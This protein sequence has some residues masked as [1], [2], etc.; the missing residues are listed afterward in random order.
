MNGRPRL[1]SGWLITIY[2]AALAVSCWLIYLTHL[3]D[4][5]LLLFM[6]G[7]V[8]A[9]FYYP[10]SVYLFLIAVTLPVAVFLV[11]QIVPGGYPYALLRVGF[12]GV[13]VLVI[14]EM[15]RWINNQREA[16]EAELRKSREQYRSLLED[17]NDVAFIVD[18][19]GRFVYISPAIERISSYTVEELIGRPFAEFIH[20]DDLPEL[21][22]KIQAVYQGDS[23][24]KW[25]RVCDRDGTVR[26]VRTSS[27]PLYENGRLVG[28]SGIMVDISD[29]VQTQERLEMRRHQLQLLNEITRAALAE[30]RYLPMLHTLEGRLAELFNADG[31]EITLWNES[32]DGLVAAEARKGGQDHPSQAPAVPAERANT[33]RVLKSGRPQAVDDVLDLP[34]GQSDRSAQNGSRSLL[35]LPLI[36]ENRWLG[37]ASIT[38]AERRQFSEEDLEWAELVTAQLSLAAYKGWALEAERTQQETARA[39][40][41]AG[42]S[43][44]ETLDSDEILDRLLPQVRNVVS[45]DCGVMMLVEGGQVRVVRQLGYREVYS[46]AVEAAISQLAFNIDEMANL[47]AVV[48]KREPLI[49]PDVYAA[50]DW[51]PVEGITRLRCWVGVPILIKGE[52]V[53]LY[54]LESERPGHFSPAHVQLLQA[55]AAQASL[56]LENARLYEQARR[57]MTESETL[58]QV[59]SA[60]VSELDLEKVLDQILEQLEKVVPYDSASVF[61]VEGQYLQILAARGFE[62]PEQVMGMTVP[63]TSTLFAHI[64]ETR[65]PLILQDAQQDARFQGWAGTAGYVRGW[66]GVP[67]MVQGE[68]IGEITVDSRLAEA[69]DIED[70]RLVMDFATEASIAIQHARLYRR[71]METAKRLSIL[72][73]A[74]QQV[75]ASLDPLQL[76]QAVHN[77][78]SQVMSTESFVIA[79]QDDYD[80]TIDVPYLVDRGGMSEPITIPAGSGLSGY[81][82]RSGKS[83]LVVDSTDELEFE[84]VQYGDPGPIRSFLAVPLRRQDGGVFGMVSAQSYQPAAYDHADLELLELLAAHAAVALDNTRLFGELQRLAIIDELT[85][86]YNRRHF[87]EV[88]RLE[89]ERARRYRR[90]L[91]IIMVDIDHFKQVNDRLGHLVGDQV[92]RVVAQRCLENMRESDVVGRYGGEEFIMLL[93]ETGQEGALQSAER[94]RIAIADAPIPARGQSVRVTISIGWASLDAGCADLDQLISLADEALY[95]AKA[96]GRNAVG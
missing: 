29:I 82:I 55:F 57:Q 8:L 3:P 70:A 74:S 65:Q 60:V 48:S 83:I 37:A 25:F 85:G 91:S 41:E 5:L 46:P 56:A 34:D 80:N 84:T 73:Q 10:R 96:R 92:L 21:R 62:N 36:A 81:I 45:Y 27:Q 51:Q 93:P 90:P 2:L 58:R 78:A 79:V 11:A 52:V 42:I 61:I 75:S 39:L 77:A 69:Y 64:N 7:I 68:I 47:S 22:E 12:A 24:Q 95:A 28:L 35:V 18:L 53:A 13:A 9:A 87:F 44:S 6:V 67:L 76:Y 94:L 31:C 33:Y 20:P 50:P 86:L 72:H 43:L 32:S 40:R 88:A 16:A 54:S 1:S 49:V 23:S 4:N 15:T 63:R 17:I 14:S 38:F 66:M 26:H 19:E 59:S 30:T 89:F 71:Q